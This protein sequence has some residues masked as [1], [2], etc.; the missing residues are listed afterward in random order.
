MSVPQV[1]SE[2]EWAQALK[3]V[4]A[5]EKRAT[6]ASDA[7]AARRRPQADPYSWWRRHEEYTHNEVSEEQ[8]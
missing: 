6:R 8:R 5:D 1:V 7:L 2:P 3:E 4:R